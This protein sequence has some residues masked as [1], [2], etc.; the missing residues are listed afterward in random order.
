MS[1][2]SGHTPSPLSRPSRKSL[3]LALLPAMLRT[4]RYA[5]RTIAALRSALFTRRDLL[6]E[7]LALRHQLSRSNRR[8]RPSDRLFWLVLRWLWPR[9]REGLVL[10]KPATVD[11]WHREGFHRWW[12]RRSRRSWKT[13]IDSPCRDLI[14]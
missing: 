2:F 5:L 6:L 9:W 12:R 3:T 11:Q 8:F 10:V 4:M 7:T 1:A 13:T 14:R